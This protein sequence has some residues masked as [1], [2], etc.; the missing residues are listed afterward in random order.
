MNSSN[1]IWSVSRQI[2]SGGAAD[3]EAFP[4]ERGPRLSGWHR[5]TV[6]DL[7]GYSVRA[8]SFRNLVTT[9]GKNYLLQCGL[10]NAAAQITS[11]YA[12]MIIENRH[13][14]DGAITNGQATLTSSSASFIAGERRPASYRIRCGRGECEPC[15]DNME[16]C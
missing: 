1:S 13:V 10:A 14:S 7:Q 3:G 16:Y 6:Y 11:W 12:G 9:A 4:A 8:D 2:E 5:L 15:H